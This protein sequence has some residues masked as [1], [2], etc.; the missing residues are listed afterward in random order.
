M[1]QPRTFHEKIPQKKEEI[2]SKVRPKAPGYVKALLPTLCKLGIPFYDEDPRCQIKAITLR[3]L[4]KAI[5]YYKRTLRTTDMDV[6]ERTIKRGLIRE[7]GGI[8]E[9]K[10]AQKYA[11]NRESSDDDFGS[12]GARNGEMSVMKSSEYNRSVSPQKLLGLSPN[13]ANMSKL[14]QTPQKIGRVNANDSFG[15][16]LRS[17]GDYSEN[18]SGYGG[19]SSLSPVKGGL[20][21]FQ[22]EGGA[23]KA[24]KTAAFDT[25]S[26]GGKTNKSENYEDM[27]VEQIDEMIDKAEKEIQV[28]DR[29]KKT[30][31]NKSIKNGKIK[32]ELKTIEDQLRTM[33]LK[34]ER[35]AVIKDSKIPFWEKLPKDSQFYKHFMNI[36]FATEIVDAAD[37][38]AT[39]DRELMQKVKEKVEH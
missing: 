1:G 9:R 30:L 3:N 38:Q 25:K 21:N 16:A 32:K 36:R 12:E 17:V 7:V 19:P 37:R 24:D 27:T 22:L 8:I 6:I 11:A 4:P 15:G 10:E 23:H 26:V 39:E 13:K 14:N 35:W 5:E 20:K 31:R 29:Q 28:L 34:C 33:R 18:K 2:D